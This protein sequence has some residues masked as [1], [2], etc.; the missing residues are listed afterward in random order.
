MKCCM[1]DESFVTILNKDKKL[2]DIN[3]WKLDQILRVHK[4]GFLRPSQTYNNNNY[5]SVP[6]RDV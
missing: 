5:T 3:Y 6:A 4:T 2:L 1:Y